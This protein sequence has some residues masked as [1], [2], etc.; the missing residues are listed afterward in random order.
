MTKDKNTLMYWLSVF[1]YGLPL[2]W[3]FTGMY[4]HPSGDKVLV[5]IVLL[6]L[7]FS[8][9]FN[10]KDVVFN[11][12]NNKWLAVV[13]LYLSFSILSYLTYGF[14]SRE[15]RA[16]AIA[17]VFFI[18]VPTKY[19]T[20]SAF[21]FLLVLGSI[22]AIVLSVYFQI[23]EPT[24]RRY[25][26]VNAIPFSNFTSL[27]V[28]SSF[29][30]LSF[31][32]ER[33]RTILMS[34]AFILSLSATLMTQTRGSIIALIIVL[35]ML[36][37]SI[38]LLKKVYNPKFIMFSI[39]SFFMASIVSLPFIIERYD[40]TV[41]EIEKIEDGNFDTS[42]GLRFSVYKLSLSFIE[43]APLLGHGSNTQ[44][45]L[46]KML[47]SEII[48]DKVHRIASW[49]FHNGY[50]EK[51][52][53]SGIVGLI[54]ML[55]LL[56]LPVVLSIRKVGFSF[57]TILIFGLSLMFSLI[58]ITDTPFTNGHSFFSYLLFVGALLSY[59]YREGSMIEN[60]KVRK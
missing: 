11:I 2:L 12:K 55:G 57:V 41:S 26:P 33:V 21:V 42:I 29:V 35:P 47:E 56:I 6:T 9:S 5:G 14:G 4:W 48:N 23:I 22:N 30:I 46:D 40:N 36:V 32:K 34:L 59:I 10:T 28:I 25:W 27:I 58:N 24:D 49:N 54:L 3:S 17:A 50:L 31:S 51:L 7:L 1:F 20:E 19:Y 13:F 43:E 38:V 45:K 53:S 15:L 60:T 18:A 44:I 37:I 39:I 16:A 52:V 8:L